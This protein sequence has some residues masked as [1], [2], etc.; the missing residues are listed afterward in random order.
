M[1]QVI[2]HTVIGA[3]E[4][5]VARSPL[6]TVSST[7][8]GG[9]VT[10]VLKQWITVTARA[11]EFGTCRDLNP[12]RPLAAFGDVG[13]EAIPAI[14]QGDWSAAGRLVCPEERAV[15]VV[16]DAD[17][18]DEASARLISALLESRC[19]VVLSHHHAP[20]TNPALESVVDGVSTD[21]Q[22]SVIVPSFSEDETD[23]ALRDGDPA[24][25]L[26]ATG[27]NPLALSLYRRSGFATV[28]V[29]VLERFDR[30]SA[31]GQALA[32]ILAASPEAIPLPLLDALGR[33][34]ESHGREL[35]RSD[36]VVADATGVA[37]RHDK[38]RRVIYEEMTAVRRRFVHAEILDR[39][40]EADDVTTVMYHAVGAGDVDT[41]IR[42]GPEAAERAASVGAH[43][44]AARHLETVMAYE[45]S[46]PE[47]DRASLREALDRHL[48]LAVG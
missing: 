32:A 21:D 15:Y 18:L 8:A 9:G 24:A 28:A 31:D 33:P 11:T 5:A 37:L 26:G 14:A 35:D 36:L 12:Q 16:D 30:L 17:R 34:W 41:I 23:E 42:R 46:V 44:E 4:E 20:S 22:S 43:R 47:A 7:A 39:L 13:D 29:A 1:E 3:I 19:R 10:T 27:G 48:A 45:H 25:A 2:R 40:T 6:V 38:V